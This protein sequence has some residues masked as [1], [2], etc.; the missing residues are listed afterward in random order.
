[1]MK[2]PIFHGIK[3][4]L[5]QDKAVRKYVCSIKELDHIIDKIDSLKVLAAPTKKRARGMMQALEHY[6]DHSDGTGQDDDQV[7][8]LDVKDRINPDMI[9]VIKGTLHVCLSEINTG[10][11]ENIV[12]TKDEYFDF[13]QK[14]EHH[15]NYRIDQMWLKGERTRIVIIP[16][17]K[18]VTVANQE[19]LF[20][21]KKLKDML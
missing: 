16:Y 17:P 1:M 8:I 10:E 4:F 15:Q 5:L 11:V 2:N 3:K 7:I 12:V 18:Y 6:S 13:I 9:F 21:D 14:N 19:Y 20:H